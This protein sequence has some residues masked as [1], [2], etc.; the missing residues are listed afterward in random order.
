N[1]QLV[2]VFSPPAVGSGIRALTY[3]PGEGEAAPLA[4]NVYLFA[5]QGVIDAGQAGIAGRNVILGAVQVL[6]ANNIIFSAGSV[7][8]PVSSGNLSGLGALT[9]TSAVTQG[10]Q[11]QE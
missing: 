11:N 10:L 5:P 4:G 7:G 9:G 3:P 6:N 1:G 8:V 2:E